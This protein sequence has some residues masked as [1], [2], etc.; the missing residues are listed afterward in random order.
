[1]I[2]LVTTAL[3]SLT[4][5]PGFA[6]EEEGKIFRLSLKDAREYAVKHSAS[7]R[8]ARLDVAMAK[9]K[10]WETTAA[11]LPQI[12]AKMSYMDNLQIATTLI[13]AEFIDPDAE[14]GT[15]I[16]VK[17]GTQHNAVFEVSAS[18]LIFSGSYFVAL[19]ASR[20]YLRLSKNQLTRSEIDVKEMVTRT[21]Y[22]VLLAENNKKI[23]ESTLENVQ[24]TLSETREL[25]NAGFVEDT[26][27]DQIRISAT[28]LENAVKS[29]ERQIEVTYNLLKYQ[30]GLD[31]HREIQLTM[32]LDDI[33]NTI[34]GGRLLET[35]FNLADH[36]D[37]RI[38]ETREKS[39][40]LL[41]KNEK[42]TYLPEISAFIS[43][44]EMAMRDSFNFFNKDGEWFPSTAVGLNINIPIFSFGMRA[45][46]VAQARLELRKAGN[47]KK[48]AA[49]GLRL[50][51]QQ[52]R[53]EF[54]NALEKNQKTRENVELA[55]KIHDKTLVKYGSGTASSLELTQTHNQYLTAQ[56]N[57][58]AA[59]VELLNAKVRLDRIL[60]RL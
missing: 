52:A 37:Y 6:G 43:H 32:T 58:T 24:Q 49:D 11:G 47:D 46:R 53:S 25:L 51:L 31:L 17:F 14:P 9:K 2:L 50:E 30:M 15:F 36:I 59:V 18:Q 40:R 45:A 33:L 5:S 12:N 3:W 8:N 20:I 60:N 44:S 10:I 4:L 1:M 42:T 13:P 23:L 21:Y 38:L 7:T 39:L 54:A 16:G 34:D 57:Y 35:P 41:L 27:A 26:D 29:I 48:Q 19:Q 56:S 22:L 28:E 55:K